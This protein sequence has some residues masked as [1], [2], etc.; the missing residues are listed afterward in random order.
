M[1]EIKIEMSNSNDV[2]VIRIV[3]VTLSDAKA[4]VAKHHRHNKPPVGWLFGT[5]LEVNG[6]LAGVAVAGRPVARLLDKPGNIEITRVCVVNQK[7]G[8][9]RLYGAILRAAKA[10]GYERAYTYTLQSESGVSMRAVGFEVDAELEPRASW[11]CPSRP[12]MQVDLFGNETRPP[13][14]KLRWIKR[15]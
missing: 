10:L 4:F 2:S 6:V 8:N 9:S 15:L 12:R 1:S 13:E 5:G 11:S 3:P 14:A 7:N